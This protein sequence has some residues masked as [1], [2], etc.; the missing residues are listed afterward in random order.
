MSHFLS[1]FEIL[2][3]FGGVGGGQ[4]GSHFSRKKSDSHL[5][6]HFGPKK[7]I[8]R[9]EKNG[10]LAKRGLCPLPK[11]EGFETKTAKMTSGHSIHENK[12][13]AP[14]T[15]ENEENDENGG[16]HARKDPVC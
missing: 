6:G 2:Q 16:C 9:E 14:Q 13:F 15:P 1:D 11:T 7:N 3:G 8:Y 10:V 12:G 5:G 4:P